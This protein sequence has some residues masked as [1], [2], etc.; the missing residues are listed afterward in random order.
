MTKEM[1]LKIVEN[2]LIDNYEIYHY[3]KRAL[4]KINEACGNYKLENLSN[5]E[6]YTWLHGIWDG[7]TR[8]HEEAK[9]KRRSKNDDR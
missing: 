5:N 6:I 4:N 8:F 3:D 7:L 2:L 9:L 1:A